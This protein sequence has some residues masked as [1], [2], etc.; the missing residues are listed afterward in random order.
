MENITTLVEEPVHICE[1]ITMWHKPQRGK[2][3]RM[4]KVTCKAMLY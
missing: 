1:K 2:M 4:N 3:S